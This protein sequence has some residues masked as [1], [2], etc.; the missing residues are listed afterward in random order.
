MFLDYSEEQ[1]LIAE[2]ARDFVRREIEPLGERYDFNKP[3]TRE[4]FREIWQGLLPALLRLTE[5][6]DMGDLDYVS[7]GIFIEELFKANPS[8]ACTIG[9][10][11]GPAGTLHLFASDELK[12]RYI[13]LIVSGQKIG[14]TAITEPNVGSNPAEVQSTAVLDGD[15][16]LLNGTKT[17]ISC[18]HISDIAM[19]TCRIREDGSEAPGIL[20]V[21]REESPYAS[22]ELPHLGL[23]GF[24]TGELYFDDCRVPRENRIG[25]KQDKGDREGLRMVFQGFEYARTAMALGAVA[26]AQAA[27]EH[28]V[29]Y[30]RERRQWG[31]LIGEHQMIQ[32][33]I[34]DMATAIDCARFLAYRTLSL[35]QQ[36][37]RCD[38]EAC[39][40]KYFATEMAVEVTSKA[41]QIHGANGLSEEYPVERIFRD[42]RMFTIPDGTTQIQKLIVARDILGLSAFN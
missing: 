35:L 21:D 33:M 12:A 28:A 14:C 8:L 22:S 4:E 31:K 26:M 3:I 32:E 16:Y 7:L 18:A 6:M 37:K 5:G 20:L 23:K 9:M 11:I 40:A 1:L 34:T 36:G 13:P 25:G 41:I 39:M 29:S 2:T 24:P 42:A 19:V 10:A 15:A 27:F 38:R 30:A 17:W